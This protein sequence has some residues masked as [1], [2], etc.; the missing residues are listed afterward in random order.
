MTTLKRLD[1]TTVL[2]TQVGIERFCLAGLFLEYRAYNHMGADLTTTPVD[3]IWVCPR[4]PRVLRFGEITGRN[5]K[6]TA[7]YLRL[8]NIGLWTMYFTGPG[9]YLAGFVRDPKPVH[10]TP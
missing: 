9:R 3:G 2:R 5:I 6:S 1:L 7:H 10:W 8:L 4:S